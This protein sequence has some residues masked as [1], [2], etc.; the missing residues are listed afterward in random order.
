MLLIQSL[1]DFEELDDASCSLV[2]RCGFALGVLRTA[3]GDEEVALAA[4][5]TSALH[6]RLERIDVPPAAGVRLFVL[7]LYTGPP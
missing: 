6:D 7:A 3:G 2:E 1:L 4:A 5:R